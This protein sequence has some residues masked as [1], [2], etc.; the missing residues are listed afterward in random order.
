VTQICHK[1][2]YDTDL[3]IL[4]PDYTTD[5]AAWDSDMYAW[6]E[7]EGLVREFFYH[8]VGSLRSSGWKDAGKGLTVAYAWKI[9]KATSEQKAAALAKAIQESE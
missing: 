2:E 6:I 5:P 8:L 7:G 3:S 4:P 1:D 9:L